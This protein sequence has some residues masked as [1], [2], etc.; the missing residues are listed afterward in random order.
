VVEYESPSVLS[1]FEPADL[2]DALSVSLVVLDVQLC[3]I[4]ANL[5]AQDAQSVRDP[6]AWA[7]LP[8]IPR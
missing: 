5:A 1:H 8:Q 6:V 3:V 7:P 2:L 4:F